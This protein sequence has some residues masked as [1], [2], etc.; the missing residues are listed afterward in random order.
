MK[1]PE[2][3]K[4]H[5]KRL[6]TTCG[7]GYRFA[8]LPDRDGMADGAFRALVRQASGNGTYYVTINQLYAAQ[9]FVRRKPQLIGCVPLLAGFVCLVP[10]LA[11][12][13]RDGQLVPGFIVSLLGTVFTLFGISVLRN[14]AKVVERKKF[15]AAAGRWN[16]KKGIAPGLIT[17]PRLKKPPPDLPEGDVHDYGVESMLVVQR[18]ELVDWLVLN[19]F[20][21]DHRSLV[22]SAD[23]YPKYL[24]DTAECL[25]RETPDLPVYLLHDATLE[26][27]AMAR[28]LQ[29]GTASGMISLQGH[30]VTDLGVYP[31]DF[32]RI[33]RLKRLGAQKQDYR[34]PID[35]LP[36]ATLSSGLAVAMVEG[37]AL[38]ALLDRP[39]HYG[40]M[41]DGGGFG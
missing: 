3:H 38:G 41:A 35:Y 31:N 1:C 15:G 6:G 30:S 16:S 7:C 2:C 28:E 10:G 32:K 26:G 4:N 21:A 39:A 14:R 29:E 19:K 37:V 23:G 20:H 27:E 40:G 36:F 34:L 18:K 9:V 11:G 25:L 33:R 17:K 8:L 5:K 22:I 12:A 13:I 24:R